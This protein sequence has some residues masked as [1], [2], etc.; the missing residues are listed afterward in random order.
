MYCVKIRSRET[1]Q[2]H[3]RQHTVMKTENAGTKFRYGQRKDSK[4][5]NIQRALV[6]VF[7]M[8]MHFMNEENIGMSFLVVY[9]CV[10][11]G[12]AL[13]LYHQTNDRGDYPATNDVTKSK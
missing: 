2:E 13:A 4:F 11:L 3:V 6:F 12:V 7:T 10:K 5:A 8:R 9:F 1:K